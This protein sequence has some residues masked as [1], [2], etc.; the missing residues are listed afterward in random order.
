MTLRCTAPQFHAH[1]TLNSHKN[2]KSCMWK[3]TIANHALRV[4]S[5]LAQELGA[6]TLHGAAAAFT[7]VKY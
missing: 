3:P 6:V 7:T 4:R 2:P 5:L 1:K